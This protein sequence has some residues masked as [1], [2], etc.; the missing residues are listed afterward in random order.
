[1]THLNGLLKS[2]TGQSIPAT[3]LFNR[4]KEIE[5]G[6]VPKLKVIV[7]MAKPKKHIVDLSEKVDKRSIS[8]FSKKQKNGGNSEQK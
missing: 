7:E 8:E 2:Q 6:I 1:M 3:R 4:A 5:D